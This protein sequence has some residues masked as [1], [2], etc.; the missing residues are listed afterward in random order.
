MESEQVF[1]AESSKTSPIVENIN[2]IELQPNANKIDRIKRT[3]FDPRLIS[4]GSDK[5]GRQQAVRNI[6]EI[7]NL[8][9]LLDV[10]MANNVDLLSEIER[11]ANLLRETRDEKL[12]ALAER[13][14]SVA[15]KLKVLFGFK[16]KT[17]LEFDKQ[18]EDILIEL[19]DLYS[20]TA[21][22]EFELR[23][24]KQ[25]REKLPDP[26]Q[27]L[28]AYYEKMETVPLTNTEKRELLT[29]ELLAELST[30]EY[31]ALWRR[32]NPH[33]LS[34]V[35]RQGFRDHN[36]MMYHSA[37]L[38]EFHNG[39]TSVL[40]DAK[41]LRP[42]IAVNEGLKGRDEASVRKF[43]EDWVLKAD[44]E[45]ES[46][47]RLSAV[48]NKTLAVAPK[49]PDKT[50]VHFAAQI[51][52]DRYYGGET[53]NEIFFLYPSDVLAS[54]H[55]Y[56]FNG[57]EKDFTKPQ[58]ET[59]WNDVFV[60]PTNMHDAGIAVDSGLVLLPKTTLVDPET[61]S[62]YASETKIIDGE[63]KLVLIEDVELIKSYIN[64]AKSLTE[65]SLVIRSFKEYRDERNYLAQQER[66]K[67]FLDL[68]KQEMLNLGFD[69]AAAVDIA[70]YYVNRGNIT[71]FVNQES[72]ESLKE[73][74][75][76]EH[77]RDIGANWKKA[78]NTITSKQ[79][80]ENYFLNNPKQKP[81][82]VVY[83]NESPT[84]A[85]HAFQQKNNIGQADV[86]ETEGKLLG[87]KDKHVM[88]LQTDPRATAG[89][90]ELE[91]MAHKI[92]AEHYKNN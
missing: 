89:Y 61:G 92:I 39:F 25:E 27:M 46:K 48:L 9:R 65:D 33:F 43:L 15:A 19:G 10:S 26:K 23:Q 6:S 51:V 74:F 11:Q 84:L 21:Q 62:K 36:A 50:A 67:T 87:F 47:A 5:E 78:E 38:Q 24:Y 75:A 4:K 90:A 22:T 34:H 32:L 77:L 82:H 66:Q 81:K 3:L 85:I 42:P 79:Y 37:G 80:W 28:E 91:E 72:N 44:D 57:F 1:S 55:N 63:E 73:E 70:N 8:S 12:S 64:W 14:E 88:D 71:S 45:E 31:I 35:T 69:E 16:D 18:A 58:S 68:T 30:D 7:R 56:A 17:S 41:T 53:G 29:P 2:Q 20:Q 49:Y 83:Y 52:A 54:Q 86:S 13:T 40:E 59:K 76:F 60:W